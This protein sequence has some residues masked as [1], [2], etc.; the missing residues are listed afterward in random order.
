MYILSGEGFDA[1]SMHKN[2]IR[3]TFLT[4]NTGG[5]T[6]FNLGFRKPK[7]DTCSRC[8]AL[9]ISTKEEPDREQRLK[10]ERECDD[11]QDNAMFAY[12]VKKNDKE[13]TFDLL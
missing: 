4:I 9:K 2:L 1:T 11:Y 12:D 8:D 10:V 7:P 5:R 3:Q 6:E 13:V